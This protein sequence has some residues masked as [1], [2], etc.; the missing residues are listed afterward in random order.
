MMEK[1]V[2][3]YK[4]GRVEKGYIRSF[5]ENADYVEIKEYKTERH[6]K[7]EMDELKAVFFVRSFEG[8]PGYKEKKRYDKKGIKARKVFVK[9]KDKETV[10]GYVDSE[11]PWDKGFFLESQPLKGKG[12]YIFP[13]DEGSNNIKI[14]IIASSVEDLTLI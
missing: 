7:A 1:V 10:L 8:D 11:L 12:F 6:I 4:D 2:L 9:F 13:V 3:R 14:F 5:S